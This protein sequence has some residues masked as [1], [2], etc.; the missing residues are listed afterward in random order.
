MKPGKYPGPGIALRHA[1]EFHVVCYPSGGQLWANPDWTIYKIV[2]ST[3]D[4]VYFNVDDTVRRIES[5]DGI[6]TECQ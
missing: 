4:V 2:Y 5:Y 6:V 1:R 3:G